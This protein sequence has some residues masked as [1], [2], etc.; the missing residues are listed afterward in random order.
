MR[1][2]FTLALNLKLQIDLTLSYLIRYSTQED[3]L[4]WHKK[5]FCWFR[6]YLSQRKQYFKV[7]GHISTY[8][9]V[10]CGV[11]QG[12]FLGPLLF[13]VSGIEDKSADQDSVYSEFQE[14]LIQHSDGWYETGRLWKAGHADLENTKAG[15]LGRLSSLVK[16][17]KQNPSQ[18]D[19][20]DDAIGSAKY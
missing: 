8:E 19:H 18:F 2:L 10:T 3:L 15:S 6:S 7:G 12:S 1:Q 9:D 11:P 5:E 13:L 16:K 20:Y 14:Q 4:I 17:L